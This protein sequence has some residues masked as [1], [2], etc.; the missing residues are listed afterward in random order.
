MEY[1]VYSKTGHNDYTV[2]Y[3][4]AQRLEGNGVRC[5]DIASNVVS[6]EMVVDV[7]PCDQSGFLRLMGNWRSVK[8][9]EFDP[10]KE[11]FIY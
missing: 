3:N 11:Y 2:L 1:L 9:I 6:A 7:D 8:F 5:G 4:L 10:Q